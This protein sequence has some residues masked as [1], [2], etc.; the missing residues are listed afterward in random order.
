MFLNAPLYLTIM[1]N[2]EQPSLVTMMSGQGVIGHSIHVLKVMLRIA[3]SICW[4]PYW[5]MTC[6]G[7]LPSSGPLGS[8]QG[9]PSANNPGYL[10]AGSNDALRAGELS[11]HIQAVVMMHVIKSPFPMHLMDLKQ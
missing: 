10:G 1:L 9:M 6:A 3:M 5:Q 2:V 11:E 7:P 8:L 4:V